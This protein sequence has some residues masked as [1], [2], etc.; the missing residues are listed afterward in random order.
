MTYLELSTCFTY[1]FPVPQYRVISMD[2]MVIILMQCGDYIFMSRAVLVDAHS[3]LVND[4]REEM[5]GSFVWQ[6][7]ESSPGSID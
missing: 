6:L 7:Q 2:M 3:A 1:T 5:K 4:I